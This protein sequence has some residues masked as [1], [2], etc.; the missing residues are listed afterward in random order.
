MS[1]QIGTGAIR[2]TGDNTE[3]KASVEDAKRSVKSLGDSV[4]SSVEQGSARAQKS[5]DAY[6]AKLRQQAGNVGKTTT[7]LKLQELAQRGATEAQLA[8]AAASLKTLDA[9]RQQAAEKRKL[10]AETRAAEAAAAAAAKRAASESGA[11]AAAAQKA[12]RISAQQSVQLGYQLQDFFIQVQAGQSPLTAFIQQGSQLSGVY[13]GAGNAF[14]AVLQIFTPFR[15]AAGGV[16]ATLALL[17]KAVYDGNEESRKFANTLVL[18]GNAAGIT[19]GKFNALALSVAD[20]TNSSIG[21]TRSLLEGL[22]ASGRFSGDTLRSAAMTAQNFSR[23]TGQS[24]DEV[25]KGF[26]SLADGVTTG[27]EKLNKQYN[28]LTRAQYEQIRAA[29]EQGDTNKALQLTFEALNERVKGA[30]DNLGLLETAGR[31]TV[32]MF[33]NLWDWLKSIGREQTAEQKLDTITEKLAALQRLRSRPLMGGQDALAGTGEAP[34]V[35]AVREEQA[36]QQELIRLMNR[37]AQ[38]QAQAAERN[39]A[40]IEFSKLSAEMM[41][42]E[43]KM[44][45]ELA[46]ANALAD[47]AGV[48][49]AERKRVL[50]DIREKYEDKGAIS[51]ASEL[52]KAKLAGEIEDIKQALKTQTDAYQN[53][54]TILEASRAAGIVSDRDYYAF[55]RSIVDLTSKVQVEALQQEN[56]R[57]AKEKATGADR[58]RNLKEIAKNE[59]E[60]A[61]VRAEATSKLSVLSIQEEAALKARTLALQESR[62]AAEEY[63]ASLQLAGERE[64]AAFGRGDRARDI[65]T[66]R[67]Q[68]DDK[69]TQQ[70]LRLAEDLRRGQLGATPEEAQ[71][72]YDA[73]LAI[74]NEFNDKALSAYEYRIG[75]QAELEKNASFGANRAIENYLDSASNVAKQTEDLYTKTFTS[76]EDALVSFVTTGK[77]NFKGLADSIIAEIARIQIKAALSQVFG[78]GSSGGGGL[79]GLLGIAKLGL[80]L[81]SGTPTGAGSFGADYSLASTPVKFG[82]PR[83]AGGPVYPNTLHP[84]NERGPELLTVGSRQYLMMGAQG[85]NVTPNS[86]IGGMPTI[87]NQTTGRVDKATM[88]TL[89][90]GERALLLQEAVTLAER[91]VNGNLSNPNSTT[92]RAMA[93]NYRTERN[94]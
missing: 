24:T 21:S 2:L 48:S 66:G 55:K 23:A 73:E 64:L 37:G 26:V 82:L 78:G 93:R 50:A 87:I 5:I 91:R 39:K 51:K 56:D 52:R 27:A 8:D 7:E 80:S 19:E 85:G 53:A 3:L 60:I 25:L 65:A 63:L 70:R 41:K 89:P 83:A 44:A 94:R 42:K 13:G 16:A 86:Q 90:D 47:K 57:I 45:K 54:E 84:V 72:R 9:Y 11:A 12:S 74:I 61:R 4:G 43:A 29:E 28:F 46:I 15:I 79:G 31:G 17:A 58:Q 67:N 71:Q 1:E 38:A 22:I 92:S 81:F 77:L 59:Q 20:S 69:Y 10:A 36:A 40:G 34:A 32:N 6:I 76:I 30:A 62:K 68:I 35:A 88:V 33:S 18:T 75:K 14:R 49:A